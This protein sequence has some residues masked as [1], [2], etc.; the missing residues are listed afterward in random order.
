MN[1]PTQVAKQLKDLPQYLDQLQHVL[2]TTP[3]V[4]YI[5]QYGP[6]L[7]SLPELIHVFKSDDEPMKKQRSY[8]QRH[9]RLIGRNS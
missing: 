5:K 4:P 1:A 9:K 2:K 6:L 3:F 7:K 8:L